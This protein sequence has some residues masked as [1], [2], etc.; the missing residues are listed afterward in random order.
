MSASWGMWEWLR[1]PFVNHKLLKPCMNLCML[2]PLHVLFNVFMEPVYRQMKTVFVIISM[3]LADKMSNGQLIFFSTW[4]RGVNCRIGWSREGY[5]VLFLL[6]EDW[7]FLFMWVHLSHTLSTWERRAIFQRYTFNIKWL[8][9]NQH[10][11][12]MPWLCVYLPTIM[13]LTVNFYSHLSAAAGPPDSP[14]SLV[15]PL[16]LSSISS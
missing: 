7:V 4:K 10:L 11:Y 6:L 12:P 8:H 14:L 16:H 3:C 9:K 1:V 2:I 13:S 5:R 15:S